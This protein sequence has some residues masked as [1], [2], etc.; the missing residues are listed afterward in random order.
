MKASGWGWMECGLF[1]DKLHFYAN[2]VKANNTIRILRSNPL[3]LLFLH[4]HTGG[5]KHIMC[6]KIK[7]VWN[8]AHLKL[9]SMWGACFCGSQRADECEIH[10]FWLRLNSLKVY[11]KSSSHRWGRFWF[12]AVFA[13]LKQNRWKWKAARQ[14][15]RLSSSSI[16]SDWQL[17]F[18]QSYENTVFKSVPSRSFEWGKLQTLCQAGTLAYWP[19]LK[20]LQ[21]CKSQC[22][23]L[24]LKD[25]WLF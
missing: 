16:S 10:T 14:F 20:L 5:K 2:C 21:R 17:Y 7:S 12:W 1:D 11:W 6:H 3:L 22:Y 15:D 23:D 19:N 13:L 24:P 8:S 25:N 18:S 4:V 9:S